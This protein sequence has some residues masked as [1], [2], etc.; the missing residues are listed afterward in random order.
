M[1]SERFKMLFIILKRLLQKYI[2][3]HNRKM[4]AWLDIIAD[5]NVVPLMAC[6]HII[7]RH[8]IS[9]TIRGGV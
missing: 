3:I 8:K 6:N 1:Q 5:I 9:F 7:L 2:F 4:N